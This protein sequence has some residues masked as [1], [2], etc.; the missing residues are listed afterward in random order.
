M[1]TSQLSVVGFVPAPRAIGP[2]GRTE[3]GH[4]RVDFGVSAGVEPA[5]GNLRC[6]G[7]EELAKAVME[8]APVIGVL[9][10]NR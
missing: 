5:A 8:K 7:Q 3:L 10:G 4:V 6:F 9:P 1:L 2:R